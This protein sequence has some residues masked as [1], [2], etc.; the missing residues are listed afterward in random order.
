[1]FYHIKC[2]ILSTVFIE[3]IFSDAQHWLCHFCLTP[4]FPLNNIEGDFEFIGTINYLSHRDTLNYISDK[5][6]IPFELNDQDHSSNR[7]DIDPYLN[8]Y[9]SLN[10]FTSK[11][12]YYF[13]SSFN[14]EINKACGTEDL[15]SLCHL[16]IR[17]LKKEQCII[18]CLLVL[19]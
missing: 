9:N 6:F 16:N 5:L 10:Q 18:G 13:E 8:F 17:S 7:C 1:M 15:F 2:I 12:D 4:I 3:E 11:C 14:S 19:T